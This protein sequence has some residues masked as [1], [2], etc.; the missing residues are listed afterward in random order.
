[1]IRLSVRAAL[2]LGPGDLLYAAN[3][4]GEVLHLRD[5][6]DDG[7]EDPNSIVMFRILDCGLPPVLLFVATP[8]ISALLN[9]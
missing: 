9:K 2:T 3:Q 8:S 4:K 7:L 1:M 5:T 6:N